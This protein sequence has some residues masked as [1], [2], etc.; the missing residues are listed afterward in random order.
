M[1]VVPKLSGPAEK[2]PGTCQTSLPLKYAGDFSAADQFPLEKSGAPVLTLKTDASVPAEGYVLDIAPERIILS[3]RE[4]NGVFYGLHTL[5]QMIREGE[6]KVPCGRYEDAPRFPYRGF[7]IDSGRHFFPADEVKKMIDQCARLKLNVLHWHLSEDQGFRIESKKFPRLNEIASWR[8]EEDGSRYGGFYT[9]EEIKDVVAYAHARYMTVVPEIDLPG[10]TT[11]IVAAYPELSCSG[12]P[13][14]VECHWGIFPRILCAGNEKVYDFL[15]QL[16][17]E[18]CE[19]FPDKWFHIGGDEAPKDEWKKCPRCQAAIKE[20]GLKDE[21]ALQARF[22]ARLVEYLNGKG[23]TVV[24]WNEIL[25]SGDLGLG[26]V[27]QYWT[28]QGA[29][30]SALEIPRGRK[31]I[32][33]NMSSFYFDYDPSLI[34]MKGAYSYEPYIPGGE[35]IRPEQVLGLEAPLWSE[36]IET[37]ERLE[38]MAFPRMAA[39]AENAWSGHGDYQDFCRRLE[40]FEETWREDGV[41]AQPVEEAA[42]FDPKAAARAVFKQVWAWSP[43]KTEAEIKA[44]LADIDWKRLSRILSPT[45][46]PEEMDRIVE[47]VR[48]LAR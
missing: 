11:A 46:T 48:A 15:Y 8:T 2:R 42:G 45:T 7:M 43:E 31:F 25:S 3:S 40:A 19:L 23:K 6:G 17:D 9:R 37:P 47:E 34:T 33:S 44:G 4:E 10:H 16:L 29:E 27:A 5:F 20:N 21:E 18:V 35:S 39:L 28:D 32:F 36:H 30:Y 13:A 24:G 12:E 1:N 26:A 14:Q 22:T 38:Y 41:N